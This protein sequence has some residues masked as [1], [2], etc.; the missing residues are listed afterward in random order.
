M[1]MLMYA[2]FASLVASSFVVMIAQLL[3]T[4]NA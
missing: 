1:E 3:S 2:A 4:Q